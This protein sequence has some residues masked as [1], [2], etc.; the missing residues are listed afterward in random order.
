MGV[1]HDEQRLRQMLDAMTADQ[2][3]TPSDRY[4]TIKRRAVRHRWNQAV[5]ALAVAAAVTGAVVGVG[6]SGGGVNPASSSR[7]VPGWA[8]PWPDHR[9]GSVPQRIL[10]GAVLAWSHLA[11]LSGT[12]WPGA[13]HERVIWYVGQTV[14][15]G[16]V[17]AVMFEV[18]GAAGHRLVAGWATAAEVMSGQPGWVSDGSSPWILYD[19][20]APPPLRRALAIGLNTHGTSAV[21]GQN[22]DNWVVELTAPNVRYVEFSAEHPRSATITTEG[23]HNGLFVFDAGQLTAQVRIRQAVNE[24]WRALRPSVVGVP[25]SPASQ[26]PQLALPPPL[27]GSSGGLAAEL[28]GQGDLIDSFKNMR[29]GRMVT[30]RCYGPAPLRIAV[31]DQRHLVGVIACDGAQHT[32]MLRGRQRVSN[33]YVFTSGLTSYRV[34]VGQT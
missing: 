5:G 7:P 14:A 27:R 31:N 24:G 9:N 8:L 32:L 19:V 25:G 29:T 16:A 30:A 26:V 28:D 3:E 22:P 15:R 1:V 11:A 20:Q 23:G 17:V 34:A 18:D 21:S 10:D 13:A 2:P 6:V 4:R 12:T 33:L